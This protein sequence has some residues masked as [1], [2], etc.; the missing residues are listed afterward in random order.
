VW[1]QIQK[2]DPSVNDVGKHRVEDGKW[3]F[4]ALPVVKNNV[5]YTNYPRD[6]IHFV[7]GKVDDTLP[8]TQLPEKI[9]LLRLDTDFYE[10]TK[11]E[12]EMRWDR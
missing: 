8:V 7:K 1:E 12:L 5:Y 10:S 2:G 6:K 3:N 4:G 11:I 9:A